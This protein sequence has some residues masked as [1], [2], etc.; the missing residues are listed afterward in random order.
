MFQP[1]RPPEHV[2]EARELAGQVVGVLER[3]GE[4]ADEADAAGRR[5]ECGQEHRGLEPGLEAAG[6]GVALLAQHVGQQQEVEPGV[7]GEP[8]GGL[9][10]R[11]RLRVRRLG[12]D[13]PRAGVLTGHGVVHAEA[14]VSAWAQQLRHGRD[15]T[16]GSAP[17][18]P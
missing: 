17:K 14:Q 6:D 2:V 10:V 8:G 5:R 9:V 12:A 4:A 15:A 18:I 13:A 11:E 16:R 7:L 3:G 1:A